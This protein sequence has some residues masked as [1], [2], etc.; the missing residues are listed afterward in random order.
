L[1]AGCGPK[2]ATMDSAGANEATAKTLDDYD[3]ISRDIFFGNTT[4]TQGRVSP[5]GSQMSFMA[6]LDGVRNL[7]VGP[8]GKFDEVKPVTD[9]KLRG[10]AGHQWALNGRNQLYRRDQGGGESFHIFSVDMESVIIYGLA[11][12]LYGDIS[13]RR[14][15]VAQSNF[16]D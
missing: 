16:H 11:A 15:Q 8:T 10:I 12:A 5:D 2:D 13:I 6:P 9:D 7:W 1:I 14:G 3:L 4:R